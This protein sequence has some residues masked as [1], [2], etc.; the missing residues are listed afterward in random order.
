MSIEPAA[1]VRSDPGSVLSGTT[2]TRSS[3][4]PRHPSVVLSWPY[5][6]SPEPNLEQSPTKSEQSV[7]AIDG[8]HVPGHEGSSRQGSVGPDSRNKQPPP[9][10]HTIDSGSPGPRQQKSSIWEGDTKPL[11]SLHEFQ[12][13]RMISLS[14]AVFSEDTAEAVFSE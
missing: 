8:P 11:T 6:G 10:Y 14:D 3:S 9:S 7:T 1:S 5:S 4:I 2:P 13:T 12:L